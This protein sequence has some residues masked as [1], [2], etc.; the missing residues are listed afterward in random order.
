MENVWSRARVRAA[1]RVRVRERLARHYWKGSGCG[2][3][4]GITGEGRGVA[5][6]VG[7]FTGKGASLHYAKDENSHA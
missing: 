2:N 4:R 5:L 6:R 3:G 1:G 7:G